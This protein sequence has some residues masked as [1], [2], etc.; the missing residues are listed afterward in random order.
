MMNITL[1][2]TL[3]KTLLEAVIVIGYLAA[4]TAFYGRYRTLPSFLTGP[5]ICRLEAG[6]CQVLFRTK[7]AAL[8]GI[9]N[10]ALGVCY[11]PFLGM[12]LF[13]HWPVWFLF[14]ASTMAFAMTLWL[15]R[16]LIQEH[17]ECRVCWTGHICNT[18]IW[19]ILLIKFTL[20]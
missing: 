19:L 1:G 4:F 8:L 20:K 15:A 6:G 12:G 3:M 9:P 14:S 18:V 5:N 17:L 11:Y 13:W 7:N 2:S 10:S 16:I